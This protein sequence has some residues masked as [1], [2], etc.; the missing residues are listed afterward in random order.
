MPILCA[1]ALGGVAGGL[2]GTEPCGWD[3]ACEKEEEKI[4]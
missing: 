1:E 3:E 4:Q 2:G